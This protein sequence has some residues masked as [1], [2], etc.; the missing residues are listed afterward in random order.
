MSAVLELKDVTKVFGAGPSEVTAVSDA[1]FRI[2]PG[3]LVLL[4]GPSGSGKSTLLQLSG[5]LL[6]PTAGEVWLDGTEVTA[7]TEKRLPGVRLAKLGFVFQ[8]FQLL[9]NLNAVENVRLVLEAAGSGRTDADAKAKAMLG[10][11][12]LDH[13]LKALPATMSGGEKQRV[14]VA[15]ALVNDPPLILADEPTGNLDSKSGA[16][17]MNLL[18][19]AVRER[20][21]SVLCA[22]HDHRVRDLADRVIWIEDGRLRD[23][24]PAA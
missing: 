1:T 11:L 5:G 23:R 12:G 21:K 17:V 16:A 6:R 18:V 20:S 24:D 13:R 3:E 2:E 8:A 14:A 10:E 19:K 9:A 15:R 4:M 7:L 22:T